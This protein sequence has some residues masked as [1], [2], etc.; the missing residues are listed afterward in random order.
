MGLDSCIR[1]SQWQRLSSEWFDQ[2]TEVIEAWITVTSNAV[3]VNWVDGCHKSI[4]CRF[5]REPPI[6]WLWLQPTDAVRFHH[7]IQIE[8]DECISPQ[9]HN[10][11]PS[12]YSK[13]TKFHFDCCLLLEEEEWGGGRRRRRGE[14]RIRVSWRDN[15]LFCLY[16]LF[17]W[18]FLLYFFV[19]VVAV[20]VA[21]VVL[22]WYIIIIWGMSWCVE[23]FPCVRRFLIVGAALN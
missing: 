16:Y 1:L 2:T 23:W 7:S 17:I 15:C 12:D 9:N 6:N 19:A 22:L 3:T 4:A 8:F 10:G 13:S 5:R 21:V 11:L 18:S 20:V 14:G